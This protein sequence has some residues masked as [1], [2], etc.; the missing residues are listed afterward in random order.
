MSTKKALALIGV[1]LIT[2]AGLALAK[3]QKQAA[4]AER[5]QNKFQIRPKDRIQNRQQFRDQNGDGIN[6][7]QRDH[8]ND[9]IPNC[10]DPDWTPPHDGT[11]YKNRN[12][13]GGSQS[14]SRS[15]GAFSGGRA[16]ARSSFRTPQRGPGTGICDGT[17]PKGNGLRRGRR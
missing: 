12:G 8:D 7:L 4:V 5:N 6:D 9:G 17:G 1:L 14:L 10:Q 13:Q 16:L 11:G 2:G 3:E 15:P